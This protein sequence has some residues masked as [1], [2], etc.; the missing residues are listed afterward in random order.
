MAGHEAKWRTTWRSYLGL[1]C[2]PPRSHDVST[3]FT[4]SGRV[5]KSNSSER[6]TSERPLPISVSNW[7]RRAERSS[8]YTEL[9]F[10]TAIHHLSGLPNHFA[11]TSRSE[12]SCRGDP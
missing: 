8:E 5:L 1:A 4:S 7:R 11:Q 9:S 12:S 3:S 6:Q 2:H 10:S